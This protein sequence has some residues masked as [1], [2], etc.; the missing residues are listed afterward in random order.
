M[1]LEYGKKK[2]WLIG[3]SR[4]R[5]AKRRGGGVQLWRLGKRKAEDKSYHK[6][7]K[8]GKKGL[9]TDKGFTSRG[10]NNPGK[11]KKA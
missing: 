8:D 6:R 5:Q 3:L 7:V 11:Q 1:S 9:R 4:S 10:T 2:G